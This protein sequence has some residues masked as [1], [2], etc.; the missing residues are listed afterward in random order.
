MLPLSLR[1]GCFHM[2]PFTAFAVLGLGVFTV[3]VA[4]TGRFLRYW[5]G[6]ILDW[7]AWVGSRFL[8]KTLASRVSLRRYCRLELNSDANRFLHVPGGPPLET[9]AVFVPLLLDEGRAGDK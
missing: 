3:V 1:T 2:D 5:T 9:D 7:L 4:R 6:V 8:R